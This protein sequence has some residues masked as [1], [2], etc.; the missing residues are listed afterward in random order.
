MMLRACAHDRP[1]EEVGDGGWSREVAGAG[2]VEETGGQLLNSVEGRE[3]EGREGGR[4]LYITA[5]ALGR[6]LS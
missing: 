5:E 1:A 6:R 4:G 2:H 3:G